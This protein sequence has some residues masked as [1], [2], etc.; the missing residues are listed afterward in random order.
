MD[1]SNFFLN[2]RF[3]LINSNGCSHFQI[4]VGDQDGIVQLFSMKKEE[5]VIHF[6]T[7]PS[8]KIQS[9]QLSGTPGNFSFS[10]SVLFR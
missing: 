7:L 1:L 8:E 3:I 6:K 5:M 9:I 10:I 4:V 2:V